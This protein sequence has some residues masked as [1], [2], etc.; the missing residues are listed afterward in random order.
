MH[1][2]LA[3]PALRNPTAA[4]H[5]QPA[6][7][8]P[9]ANG[10]VEGAP[11]AAELQGN[12]DA[13]S[14]EAAQPPR[15]LQDVHFA[16]KRGQLVGCCGAVGAGKTTLVS[17]L[18]GEVTVRSGGV[19]LRG[20]LAYAGQQ[21]WIQ[22]ATLRENI[23]F[24]AELDEPRYRAVL[25]A[26]GLEADL[27]TLPAGDLTAIGERG[28]N[29]S[30]GQKQR[31]SLARAMY[32]GHDVLLLDDPL[33]AVDVH[34][35]EH[36]FQHAICGDMSG[37]TVLLVTHQLQYLAACDLVV[38]VSRGRVVVGTH[39]QLHTSNADYRYML[40]NSR[41]DTAQQEDSGAA[42]G[43]DASASDVRSKGLRESAQQRRSSKEGPL[44][45]HR[46]TLGNETEAGGILVK[47][48]ESVCACVCVSL[49]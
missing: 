25:A 10:T 42:V 23:L 47:V 36:I 48:R 15:V 39:E 44:T 3:W 43:P 8:G 29:L 30:G 49:L 1:A 11:Q 12:G 35:G 9:L 14:L 40:D 24:G 17:A 4:D 31:V 21:A 20:S 27:D 13:S 16:V 22:S 45:T 32:S 46:A 33:S 19:H 5:K 34:V 37:K 41:R 38:F 2:D 28:I 6:S 7:A 18:L 26:A